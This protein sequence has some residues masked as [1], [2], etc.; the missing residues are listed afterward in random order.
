M[1]SWVDPITSLPSRGPGEGGV[2]PGALSVTHELLRLSREPR[3]GTTPS[4]PR[5]ASPPREPRPAS[6]SLHV[7]LPRPQ[8]LLPSLLHTAP[9]PASGLSSHQ[10]PSTWT[11]SPGPRTWLFSFLAPQ[12]VNLLFLW[13]GEWMYVWPMEVPRLGVESELQLPALTHWARPGMELTS[14]WLLGGFVTAE[15]QWELPICRFRSICLLTAPTLECPSCEGGDL[16]RSARLGHSRYTSRCS[17]RVCAMTERR[18]SGGQMS[19][20]GGGGNLFLTLF[21]RLG[22]RRGDEVMSRVTY[23]GAAMLD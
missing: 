22:N 1:V 2:V 23:T 10:R 8:S 13:G 14:S 19:K 18:V 9:P 12:F 4:C 17:T 6:G 5:V 7:R 11:P 21:C 20:W 15:P 3:Q 16:I